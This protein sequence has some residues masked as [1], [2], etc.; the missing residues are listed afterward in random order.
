M[1]KTLI[2]VAFFRNLKKQIVLDL[3]DSDKVIDV[4]EKLDLLLRSDD[5]YSK[6]QPLSVG[7]HIY[8]DFIVY[9]IRHTHS[10]KIEVW[11]TIAGEEQRRS[12]YMPL[13]ILPPSRVE[14]APPEYIES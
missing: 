6:G 14:S 8:P 7:G 12:F 2:S 9:N 10:L 4:A 11:F 3:A 13:T 1:K 5:L